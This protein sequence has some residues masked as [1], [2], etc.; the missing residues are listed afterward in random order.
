MPPLENLG[1]SE[2][3]AFWQD[4]RVFITGH[5]G[6]KG[7]WLSLW[8]QMLGA[9]LTGYALEPPT[10]P[11]LFERARLAEGMASITADVRDLAALQNAMGAQQPDVVFHLAAQPLVRRSYQEPIETVSTNVLGAAHLL[12]AVRHTPSVRAVVMITSDK[13]YENKEWLWGYRENDDLG[14]HDPYSASKACAELVIATYRNSFFPPQKLEE[15]GVAVA[16]TRAGNVIGGG[17][18]AKDRLVPDIMQA[19]MQGEPVVIRSPRATRPWQ[20]VLEPLNGYLTLAEHLWQEGSAYAEAW[21]FGPNDADVK[22]VSWIVDYITRRWGE[23][24]SWRLDQEEQPHENTLLKLD[25]SK[26]KARLGWQP[27]LDLA[28]A[29]DWI[30]AWF[31]GYQHEEDMRALSEEQIRR[32]AQREAT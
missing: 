13:C 24:A 11:S 5:T 10:Q 19:V 15:H 23:G 6:F 22:P 18:W 9:D 7:S 1:M 3:Q 27:K 32:F 31:Q 14:G 17:D 12:E 20:H 29:L 4:K 28:T 2:R 16:S 25:C 26:A 21:N 8:L 30:V